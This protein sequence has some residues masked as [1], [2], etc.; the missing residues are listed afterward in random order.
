MLPQG[1]HA[2]PE[3]RELVAFGVDLDERDPPPDPRNDIVQP[4][5]L[6][7]MRLATIAG[8]LEAGERRLP[9]PGHRG[10][11]AGLEGSAVPGL[12]GQP[13]AAAR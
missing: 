2:A 6:H 12:G 1:R 4:E 5:Q 11:G 7:P 9:D 13:I 3:N 8:V 10:P